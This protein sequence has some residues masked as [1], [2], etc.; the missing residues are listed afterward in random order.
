MLALLASALAATAV[1]CSD[2][3]LDCARCKIHWRGGV[4]KTGGIMSED[5][6]QSQEDLRM[7]EHFDDGS[8]RQRRLDALRALAA[9]T[10][11]ESTSFAS[12]SLD[13]PPAPTFAPEATADEQASPTGARRW[14]W[15][16]LLVGLV[17]LLVVAVGA[18]FAMR[19]GGLVAHSTAPAPPALVATILNVGKAGGVFCTSTPAWAPN[20]QQIALFGQINPPRDNCQLYNTQAAVAQL[21]NGDVPYVSINRAD[22]Y[23]LVIFDS[24]SGR[25]AQRIALPAL[26]DAALC[27][28]VSGCFVQQAAFQSQAWS[29]DGHTVALFFTYDLL[30]DQYVWQCGGL[31]L[32]P[33]GAPASQP[34]FLLA[35]GPRKLL[36]ASSTRPLTT[37]FLA[38]RYA[39]NL[40]TGAAL[41][42]AIHQ[43]QP[44]TQSGDTTPFAPAY[45]WN[46]AGQ[47]VAASA[48]SATSAATSP[49]ASGVVGPRQSQ[50]APALYRTSQW[51]WS[52]DGHWVTPNLATSAYL[53]PWSAPIPSGSDYAPP[54]VTAPDT[55]TSAAITAALDSR[56]GVALARNPDGSL[57]AS[58][59][60]SAN[61][62][63]GQLA[64]RA[65]KSGDPLAQAGYTYPY[66]YYSLA[67]NGDIDLPIWSPN[68]SRLAIGDEQTGMVTIWRVNV[69]A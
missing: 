7:S 46:T 26:T 9:Q 34:R 49:W 20:S 17:A 12:S 63:V 11:Q 44:Q 10:P 2:L 50:S 3:S 58:Y 41:V 61:L 57:L 25:V 15:V 4:N 37:G 56:P 38:L 39:W 22:G 65:S 68:G 69:H 13:E 55:A 60:C 8:E 43:G 29:P 35:Q 14:W 27:R 18:G 30:S 19:R 67:C 48:S 1:Y 52:A 21:A 53:R 32:V 51:L 64:I 36:S 6:A 54:L 31:L 47:L 62:Q 28:A 16:A 42:T 24:A 40:A 33:V 45:A 66:S 23:A 5:V 59:D